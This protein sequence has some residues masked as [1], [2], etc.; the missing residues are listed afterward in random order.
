MYMMMMNK[1]KMVMNKGKDCA[2][3]TLPSALH[4]SSVVA[5]CASDGLAAGHRHNPLLAFRHMALAAKAWHGL[6]MLTVLLIILLAVMGSCCPRRS[7]EDSVRHQRLADIDD[8]IIHLSPSARRM[9]EAG[10]RDATDSMSYY[11]FYVRMA[12]Y[13]LTTATPDSMDSYIDRVVAFA[14]TQPPSPRVNAMLSCAYTCKASRYHFFHQKPDEVVRLYTEAYNLLSASDEQQMLPRLCGNLADAYFFKDDLPAAA[15]WY[16]R[17]L[18]LVDSL[19]LPKDEDVTLYLGLARIYMNLNDFDTSRK[20]YEQTA[21]QYASMQPSMQAYFLNDYGSYFYYSKDYKASLEKFLTLESMLRRNGMESNFD[22]YLCRLNL[23]DV[24][25][26][27]GCYDKSQA[28]LDFVEPYLKRMGDPVAMY[29]VNTIKI[30]LALHRDDTREVAAILRSEPAGVNPGYNIS[31]IRNAYL[32]QYYE[33]IGDFRRAYA[34]LTSDQRQTDSLNHSR[35]NMRAT[36]IM[37][38]FTEDTLRLHHSLE[39]EQKNTA[40][41]RSNT[42]AVGLFAVAVVLCL[43]LLAWMSYSRKQNLKNQLSIMRLKLSSARNRIN[44][45]FVFNVLNNKIAS[46]DEE[47]AGE[48]RDLAKLIRTNLDMSC[49]MTVSLADEISFVSRYVE[50]ERYV[51]G[52]GFSFSVS[53]APDVHPDDVQVP[54]MFL[55]ILAENAIVHGLKGLDGDKRLSISAVRSGAATRIAVTDNGRGFDV[56]AQGPD[57]R[58]GLSII[59]QTIAVVNERSKSKMRFSLRNLNGPDGHVTGCESVLVIPDGMTFKGLM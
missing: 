19:S 30:G 57:K 38:R 18:F 3:G 43:S 2:C 46:D 53:L 27:L 37:D 54:S 52:E 20:Y 49:R 29:Y 50:V 41:S 42:M 59:T 58:T 14:H 7:V 22:F 23:A 16:R 6:P 48:L 34:L 4:A 26:N 51:V 13:F 8:S 45:H 11:E 36:E 35:N 9:I 31:H 39:L 1:D 10:M 5:D 55:Q 56:R 17:A 15:S 40:I 28:C 32:R 44:P 33:R 24:Y 47:K 21:R 12:K 25:L